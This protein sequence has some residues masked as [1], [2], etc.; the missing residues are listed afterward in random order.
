[1]GSRHTY[2]LLVVDGYNVMGATD[3]YRALFDDTKRDLNSTRLIGHDPFR[4][5]RE[6][7]I[8][9]VA[10]FA[11]SHYEPVIVFD[12]A[13]N[14]SHERHNLK[15]AGVRLIFSRTGESADSVIERLVTE[16]REAGREVT[17]VTSDNTIRATVG[18]GGIS[19]MSSS[20]LT[21]EFEVVDSDI[22]EVQR[23]T[24]SQKMTL[25][26]RLSPEQRAKLWKM[27]GRS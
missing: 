25:E 10:A 12:G 7:L 4:R 18:A 5:A 20:L 23:D 16:A 27:L 21:R 9:D 13:G 6:A 8:S 17:L 2:P 11:Q 26:D 22:H 15:P 24:P 3:R 1:M 14:L 19:R